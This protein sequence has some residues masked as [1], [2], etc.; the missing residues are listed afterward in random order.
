M[1]NYIT[2]NDRRI[3]LTDEQVEQIIAAHNQSNVRLSSVSAGNTVRIGR[4]EMIVL[5]HLG[6]TAALIRKNPLVDSQAFGKNNNYD[7][8][9]VDVVCNDFADEIAAIVGDE[10]LVLHTVDL[11]SDD[12]LKDYGKVERRASLLTADLYRR[13]VEIFDRFT[14]DKWWMLATAHSTK[15][16]GGNFWIK[17]VSPSGVINY[18]G[19]DYGYSVRPFCIIKSKIFVS[20]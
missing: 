2:I 19:C 17:V 15:R 16:H 1:K 13:H 18:G 4:H 5:E 9:F 6:D 12:G 10:N 7:G 8:S 11:T 20:M 3:E 14:V